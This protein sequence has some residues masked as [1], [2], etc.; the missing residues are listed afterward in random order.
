M[1]LKPTVKDNGLNESAEDKIPILTNENNVIQEQNRTSQN[2]K[3]KKNNF[4]K[5][6]IFKK[7]ILNSEYERDCDYKDKIVQKSLSMNH[8][9]ALRNNITYSDHFESKIRVKKLN[10]LNYEEQRYSI[11]R[12]HKGKRGSKKSFRKSDLKWKHLSSDLNFSTNL[13]NI[14]KTR[15]NI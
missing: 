13:P 8:S 3:T 14:S 1:E 10:L 7:T 2:L 4:M 12:V 5:K 6:N 15:T 9:K 11:D